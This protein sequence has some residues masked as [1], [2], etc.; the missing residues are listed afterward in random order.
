MISGQIDRFF[1]GAL[2]SWWFKYELIRGSKHWKYEMRNAE[3][4]KPALETWAKPP[5]HWDSKVAWWIKALLVVALTGGAFLIDER[6]S[7]WA[8]RHLA[9]QNAYQRAASTMAFSPVGE[10]PTFWDKVFEKALKGDMARE[11]MFLEQYGQFACSVAVIAAV[12]LLDRRDGLIKALAIAAACLA[13]L[14]VMHLLK[15][16]FGRSRPF[17]Y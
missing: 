17:A 3:F 6:V 7:G 12:A 5:A 4:E 16:C 10:Q 9:Y 2:V 11:L 13:T 8:L 1:L 14:A 15:D